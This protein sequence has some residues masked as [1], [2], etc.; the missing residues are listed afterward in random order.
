MIAALKSAC[1][2]DE[3]VNLRPGLRADMSN[4]VDV[5]GVLILHDPFDADFSLINMVFAL[6]LRVIE[7]GERA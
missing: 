2:S 4:E 1:S 3:R 6:L 5:R 7:S